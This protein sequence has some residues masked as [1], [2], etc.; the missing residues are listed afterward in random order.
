MGFF[1]FVSWVS[2]FQMVVETARARKQNLTGRYVNKH[3]FLSGM[4]NDTSPGTAKAH[5]RGEM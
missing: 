5:V 3:N 2:I 4:R 1:L